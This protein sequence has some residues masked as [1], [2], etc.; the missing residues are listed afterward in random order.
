MERRLE[1][2][3]QEYD[4]ALRQSQSA[5]VIRRTSAN[6][7]PSTAPAQP[8][9]SGP[10][11][12]VRVTPSSPDT[13]A[14]STALEESNVNPF[15][16]SNDILAEDMQPTGEVRSELGE[17]YVDGKVTRGQTSQ[18]S[19]SAV[20]PEDGATSI[21]DGGMLNLLTHIYGTKGPG[22]RRVL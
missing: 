17:S 5:A 6:K 11:P 22:H 15:P 1:E 19:V 18:P 21:E 7:P 10:S 20:Q 14:Q 3:A 16:H 4:R 13:T 8:S 12:A 9:Q 2:R